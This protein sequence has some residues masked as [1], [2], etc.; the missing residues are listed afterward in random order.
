MGIVPEPVVLLGTRRTD[1]V[2]CFPDLFAERLNAYPPQ[3]VHTVVIWTKS[4]A[5]ILRHEA[6]RQALVRHRHHFLHLT[7]TGLGGSVIEPGVPR[8][9]TVMNLLP[10]LV[11][12]F[13]RAERIQI[14]FDPLVFFRFREPPQPGLFPELL[15]GQRGRRPEALGED[16]LFDAKGS[17]YSNVR[18]FRP[19]AEKAI[20]CGVTVF[21]TSF[22]LPYPHVRRR[23]GRATVELINPLLR[24]KRQVAEHLLEEARSLGI[25]LY[26][27]ATP[28][29]LPFPRGACIDGELLSRLHPDG[30]QAST[31][32]DPLQ[33]KWCLCTLAR[34]LGYYEEVCRLGCIYCYATP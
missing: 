5:P 18:L 22:Y 24:V 4:P 34:D 10:R 32:R 26:G 31:V 2:G 15:R 3:E 16:L 9:Q 21:F 28:E 27:C 14:R 33:R 19:I 6:L 7:V 8:W 25:T 29:S 11:T 1:L 13:G 23:I 30:L 17:I 12:F 20:E